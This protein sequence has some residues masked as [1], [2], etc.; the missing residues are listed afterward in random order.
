MIYLLAGIGSTLLTIY[1]TPIIIYGAFSKIFGIQPPANISPARFLVSV[2]VSK[3]GTAIAMTLLFSYA[4]AVFVPAWWLYALI[5]WS[6]FVFG[7]IGQWLEGK[8]SGKEAIAG[9]ISETIYVPL[10]VFFLTLIL[11]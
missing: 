2:L 1:V 3:I 6:L 9:I 7:E 4:K 11:P 5:W 10:A 8:Y